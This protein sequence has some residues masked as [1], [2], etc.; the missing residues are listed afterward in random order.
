MMANLP[1]LAQPMHEFLSLASRS[2]A[3]AADPLALGAI[4]VAGVPLD[5]T[6]PVDF[7]K[8]SDPAAPAALPLSRSAAPVAAHA[9]PIAAA[10]PAL[11]RAAPV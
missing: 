11:A 10:V 3:A 1:P 2:L 4:P 8:L 7:S 5:K 6:T 9:A